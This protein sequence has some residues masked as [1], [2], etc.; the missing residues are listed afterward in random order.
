MDLYLDWVKRYGYTIECGHLDTALAEASHVNCLF[1]VLVYR[2]D[3]WHAETARV[4]SCSVITNAICYFSIICT[5]GAVT[6]I[7][8]A[9]NRAAILEA[10]PYT[11]LRTDSK[12]KW[13]K[14]E[15]SRA[16]VIADRV[17]DVDR[18]SGEFSTHSTR[19]VKGNV[20]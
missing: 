4:D 20:Q 15:N 16:K 19:L 1:S 2:R 6:S 3:S 7:N 11:L 9:K 10:G 17:F 13:R 12:L 18:L 8:R 5:W 14:S